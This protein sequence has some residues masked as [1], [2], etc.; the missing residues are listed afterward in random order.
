MLQ[1]NKR[2]KLLRLDE[3]RHKRVVDQDEAVGLVADAVIR[4]RS[5]IKDPKRPIGSFIF[6]G[7]TGVGKTELAMTLAEALFDSEENMVRIDTSKY[8]E[9]HAVS[10][11]LGAPPGY[12]GSEEGGQLTEAVRGR[13]YC[14]IL[15]DEIDKAHPE[16]FNT[17]LQILDDGRLTDG[18]GPTVEFKNT[19]VA[20]WLSSFA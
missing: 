8:M 10:R 20:Q 12:V 16:V 15:F 19:V 18:Q 4:A 2:E 11:L 17:L 1:V 14:V 3:I 7:P 5:G 13:P 9:P 6:L